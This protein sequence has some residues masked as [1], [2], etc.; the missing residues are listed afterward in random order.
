MMQ[1]RSTEK[2]GNLTG[3]ILIEKCDTGESSAWLYI[4]FLRGIAKRQLVDVDAESCIVRAD[5][6]LES[7]IRSEHM[8]DIKLLIKSPEPPKTWADCVSAIESGDI[9]I[10]GDEAFFIRFS[11]EVLNLVIMLI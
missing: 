11:P 6:D 7:S 1:I 3:N 10:T 8:Y 4:E 2:I 5:F 9:S